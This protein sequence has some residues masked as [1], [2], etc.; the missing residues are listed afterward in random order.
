MKIILFSFN[1]FFTIKKF[2]SL[3]CFPFYSARNRVGNLP[4]NFQKFSFFKFYVLNFKILNFFI[5]FISASFRFESLIQFTFLY[6][7][8]LRCSD[9]LQLRRFR[10]VYHYQILHHPIAHIMRTTGE[11]K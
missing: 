5:F 2:S 9:N 8:M 10:V 1:F 7:K 6:Q 4:R 3:F 11:H